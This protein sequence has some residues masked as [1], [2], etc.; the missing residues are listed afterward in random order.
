[1][2]WLCVSDRAKRCFFFF[3]Y[4]LTQYV[5]E[6]AEL[7][8]TDPKVVRKVLRANAMIEQYTRE[9]IGIEERLASLDE[10]DDAVHS[11]ASKETRSKK[12]GDG[13]ANNNNINSSSSA[14]SDD[15][16]DAKA[17]SDTPEGSDSRN[18]QKSRSG[19]VSKS[20]SASR[21]RRARS[22]SSTNASSQH[23]S[24]DKGDAARFVCDMCGS[25]FVHDERRARWVF[26]PSIDGG[27]RLTVCGKCTR[28][29][30]ALPGARSINGLAEASVDLHTHAAP[31]PSLTASDERE[32]APGEKP[33]PIV[34]QLRH[35]VSI[36]PDTP[37]K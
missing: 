27:T 29:A 32:I 20:S 13:D 1:M 36:G 28:A 26:A 6:R 14:S 18:N 19:A 17:R 24:T 9:L 23:S 11:T 21:R 37:T 12:R 5:A 10:R 31:A 2:F 25:L 3:L 15:E 7:V 4:R 16:Y 34:F 35:V 8:E 30:R 22:A 33:D